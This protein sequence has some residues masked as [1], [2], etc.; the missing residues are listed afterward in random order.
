MEAMYLRK[1]LASYSIGDYH[2][3]LSRHIEDIWSVPFLGDCNQE[4]EFRE[5][6]N[7]YPIIY[8]T[9]H[10]RIIQWLESQSYTV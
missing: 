1:K 9:A 6:S 3:M 8:N 10:E 4:M 2:T 7:S 5:F